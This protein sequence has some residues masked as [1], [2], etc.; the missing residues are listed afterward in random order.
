MKRYDVGG[1][2]VEIDESVTG[3]WVKYDDALREQ[4]RLK[5]LITAMIISRAGVLPPEKQR[6]LD[7][8]I[9][10]EVE[11]LIEEKILD[12]DIKV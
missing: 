6:G 11:K 5:K 12:N 9:H 2:E 3:H 10:H 4:E 1:W 7:F 8:D